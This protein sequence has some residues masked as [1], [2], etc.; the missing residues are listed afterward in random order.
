MMSHQS[1]VS[2]R[3]QWQVRG[4]VL[5]GLLTL[6]VTSW[7]LVSCKTGSQAGAPGAEPLQGSAEVQ[8]CSNGIQSKRQ[9]T[10]AMN[11]SEFT[12][13]KKIC[14]KRGGQVTF[15]ADCPDGSVTVYFSNP[16]NLFTDE[17]SSVTPDKGGTVKT[18]KPD[19][20]GDHCMCIGDGCL[21]TACSKDRQDPATGSLDVATSGPS[22]D[23]EGPKQ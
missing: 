12:K 22:E 14:T 17:S 23:D 15:I 11:C 3:V 5:A 1:E 18:L 16:S 7:A 20:G 9:Y 6:G 13:N 4:R 8:T 21:A 19:A 2:R 10:V